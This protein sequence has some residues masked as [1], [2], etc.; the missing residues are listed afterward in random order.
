MIKKRILDTPISPEEALAVI[1]NRFDMTLVA[2]EKARRLK[3]QGVENYRSEAIKEI[4]YGMIGE[5]DD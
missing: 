4:K 5:N 1:P 3:R 2:A